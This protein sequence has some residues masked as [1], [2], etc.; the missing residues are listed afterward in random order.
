MTV[1]ALSRLPYSLYR[2]FKGVFERLSLPHATTM[3]GSMENPPT[4][5]LAVS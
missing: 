1:Q 2:T 5:P 4:N 3:V